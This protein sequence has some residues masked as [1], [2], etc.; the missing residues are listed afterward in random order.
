M[1]RRPLQ[2][3]DFRRSPVGAGFL[4]SGHWSNYLGIVIAGRRVSDVHPRAKDAA[5]SRVLLR[6]Q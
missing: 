4:L 6:D 5:S 1:K 3:I 2:Y